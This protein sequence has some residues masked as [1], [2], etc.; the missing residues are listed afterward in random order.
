MKEVILENTD[1]DDMT[2][3]SAI[4]VYKNTKQRKAEF[5]TN[6]FESIDSFVKLEA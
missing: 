2:P 5:K 3:D 4:P 1:E 6:A